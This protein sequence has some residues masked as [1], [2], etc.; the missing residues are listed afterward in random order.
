MNILRP[1][2]RILMNP[3]VIDASLATGTPEVALAHHPM[4]QKEASLLVSSTAQKFSPTDSPWWLWP[5][6]LS[7]DAPL[8]ALI[9]Q[10]WWARTAGV[11]LP[12]SREVVLGLGVWLIYLADR[13]ADSADGEHRRDGAARHVFSGDCRNFLQPLTVFV[14]VVLTICTPRWLPGAEFVAGLGLLAL[15]LGYFWLIHGWPGR[16]WAAYLPKEAAVGGMFAAGSVFFVVCRSSH[17]PANLW[18]GSGLFAV[19]CFLNCALIT[20]WERHVRDLSEQSSLLNSF[21]WLSA[22]LETACVALAG[23]ALLVASATH[24][25]FAIPVASSA[26][27]LAALDRYEGR[28]CTDAL[29][30]LADMVLLVPLLG[31]VYTWTVA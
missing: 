6:L 9:W 23:A 10:R 16:G 4:R 13:L 17:L 2:R 28:L 26:L 25:L 31:L 18:L 12:L 30:V 21:P 7:L 11:R 3:A 24:S 15:A 22:R 1:R 5:H 27:L 14:A 20:K 8:V 19:V 29:R